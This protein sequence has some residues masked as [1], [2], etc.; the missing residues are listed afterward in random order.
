MQIFLL[1]MFNFIIVWK[2][3]DQFNKSLVKLTDKQDHSVNIMIYY[4][5]RVDLPSK[6]SKWETF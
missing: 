5:L 2:I 1:N 3:S 4:E 6:Y